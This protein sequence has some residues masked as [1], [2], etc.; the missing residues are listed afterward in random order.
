MCNSFLSCWFA[1]YQPMFTALGA[2]ATFGAVFASLYIAIW[3]KPKAQLESL[4]GIRVEMPNMKEIL[5]IQTT[6]I[7]LLDIEILGFSITEKHANSELWLK[8][9]HDELPKRLQYGQAIRL[10]RGDKMIN[11]VL[12]FLSDNLI[13]GLKLKKVQRDSKLKR[14]CQKNVCVSVDTNTQIKHKSKLGR[15]LLERLTKLINEKL[16]NN[17]DDKK[18]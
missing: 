14:L 5:L 8:P 1:E 15:P 6:N 12:A 4:V 9:E 16:E 3:R 18:N 17:N 7:G 2:M 10:Y 11:S 13:S